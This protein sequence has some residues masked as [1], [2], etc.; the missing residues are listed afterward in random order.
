MT[1]VDDTSLMKVKIKE[2]K[3]DVKEKNDLKDLVDKVKQNMK[4]NI[5]V[6]ID[7]NEE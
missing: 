7:K 5:I 2:A 1:A 6:K 3:T 4:T